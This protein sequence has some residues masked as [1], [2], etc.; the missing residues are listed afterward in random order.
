MNWVDAIVLIAWVLTALWGLSAG[1]FQIAFSLVAV[2]VGLAVS[3]RV[4]D[5]V[6]TI[7]SGLTDNED[8][9]IIGGFILIFLGLFIVSSVL[10]FFV[11]KIG[12]FVPV[13]GPISRIAGMAAGI[14]IGF[15]ILSGV[16][17]GVQKYTDR[18]DD[19]ID[20]STLGSFLADKFDEV[21]RAVKLIPSDWDDEL[22]RKLLPGDW[23]DELTRKLLPGDWDGELTRKLTN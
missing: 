4:G 19:D 21:T 13:V 3:S 11:G 17:T 7:F 6:G 16:L 8:V 2:I 14:L 9:Q 5:D 22:T 1:L 18:V 12:R 10:G 15:L 23:D 20:E